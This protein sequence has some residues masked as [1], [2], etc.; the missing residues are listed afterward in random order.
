MPKYG[1]MNTSYSWRDKRRP[2]DYGGIGTA[3][4]SATVIARRRRPRGRHSKTQDGA[5][6]K[7]EKRIPECLEADEVNAICQGCRAAFVVYYVSAVHTIISVAPSPKAK[8]LML[9]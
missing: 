3:T 6:P 5:A 7:R 8:L 9:E 1:W 4:E 2:K